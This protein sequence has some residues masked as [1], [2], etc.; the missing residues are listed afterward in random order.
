MKKL[1]YAVGACLLMTGLAHADITLIYDDFD[2]SSIST[3]ARLRLNHA[4][5]GSGDDWKKFSGGPGTSLWNIS[6]GP[7][8]NLN[9]PGTTAGIPAEGAVGQLYTVTT[10]DTTLT[11]LKFEFDYTVGTGS[12]LYFHAN[13]LKTNG[14]PAANEIL[15]NIGAQSGAIQDL[16]DGNFADINIFAGTD[17]NGAAVDAVSFA[18]GTSGTYNAT[19]D[20]SAYTW[21]A[22]EAIVGGTTVG[23]IT[24]F[25]YL[26]LLF[27]SDVTDNTGA[28]AISIDNF[29]VTAVAVPEPSSFAMFLGGMSLLTMR[30]RRA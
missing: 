24:S 14:V 22:G 28:G 4:G 7:T 3:D 10:A 20:L 23:N 25:D 2:S 1:I 17:P 6:G 15:Y 19:F 5:D 26:A 21:E 29:R 18:A 13:G 30:R 27:A 9:N 8:G 11:Q 12:T 16:A